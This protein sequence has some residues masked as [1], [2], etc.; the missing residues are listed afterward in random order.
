MQAAAQILM[1]LK[2]RRE[3]ILCAASHCFPTPPKLPLPGRCFFFNL[4]F[5]FLILLFLP[6]PAGGPR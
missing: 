1:E 6:S 3:T 4:P 2:N 5:F